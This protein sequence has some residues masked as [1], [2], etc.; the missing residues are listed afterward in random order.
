M[1]KKEAK[2]NNDAGGCLFESLYERTLCGR[3]F[4]M[5]LSSCKAY[6]LTEKIFN[7]STNLLIFVSRTIIL[8]PVVNQSF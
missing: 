8:F 5:R 7:D 3:L 2:Q 4:K 1:N 6:F